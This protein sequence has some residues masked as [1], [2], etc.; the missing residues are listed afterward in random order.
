[1]LSELIY[2]RMIPKNNNEMI[3]ILLIKDELIEKENKNKYFRKEKTN[4]I[5]SK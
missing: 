2:K 1:M 3:D 5:S 4:F